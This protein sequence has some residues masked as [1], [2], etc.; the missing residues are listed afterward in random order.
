MMAIDSRQTSIVHDTPAFVTSEPQETEWGQ[1][2]ASRYFFVID[3]ARLYGQP[4]A[5]VYLASSDALSFEPHLAAEFADW[6]TASD[7]A[8]LNFEA[9][10]D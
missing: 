4:I 7:E 6:D 8:L 3:G 1:P 2:A 10:L 9:M 5:G